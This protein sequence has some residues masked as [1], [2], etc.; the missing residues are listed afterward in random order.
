MEYNYSIAQC[1]SF[2]FIFGI[3]LSRKRIGL[4]CILGVDVVLGVRICVAFLE[5]SDGAGGGGGG[6][7]V[8]MSVKSVLGYLSVVSYMAINNLL[9]ISII[10]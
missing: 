6:E 8:Q 1:I 7:G 5:G 4:M 3:A 9:K 2:L 10:S